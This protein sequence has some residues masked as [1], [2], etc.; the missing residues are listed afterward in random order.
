VTTIAQAEAKGLSRDQAS[1]AAWRIVAEAHPFPAT[2]G[3]ICPHTCE[4]SCHRGSKEGAVA[5]N[6]L[7]RWL[8]DVA[9]ARGFD[10]PVCARSAA[11]GR[12]AI[13]GAGPAGLSCACQL[14]R[15]GHEVDVFEAREVAGGRLRDATRTGRLAAEIVDAEIAR[16]VRLGI[17]LRC[18]TKIADDLAGLD[19]SHDFVFVATGKGGSPGQADYALR[20]QHSAAQGVVSPSNHGLRTTDYDHRRRI[21]ISGDVTRPGLVSAALASGREAA[22]TIDAAINGRPDVRT[23][24]AAVAIAADRL[25]LGYY[26]DAPRHQMREIADAADVEAIA[27]ARRCM[28]CGL[29]MDCERCWMY[30][31]TNCFEKLPKGQH[32]RISLDGC[33][34]CR[35]CAEECPCGYIDMQ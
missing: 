22:R 3:R 19:T 27:E 18:A 15:R 9:L 4:R 33:N 30:C 14:A 34:G 29:C 11:V 5:I 1:E 13:V 10:L 23:H 21:L 26:A 2:L 17:T 6:A 20:R 32:Y 24:E 8:G 28:S 25:T 12:V 7:E 16:V 31:T 35:K